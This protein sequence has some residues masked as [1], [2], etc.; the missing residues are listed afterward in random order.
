MSK[1]KVF[2]LVVIIVAFVGAVVAGIA[3]WQ[4]GDVADAITTISNSAT[5]TAVKADSVLSSTD[6]V[7]V[8]D[9]TVKD[10]TSSK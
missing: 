1:K 2:G 8:V 7:A 9:S 10:T 3:K 5:T 6:S 4:A